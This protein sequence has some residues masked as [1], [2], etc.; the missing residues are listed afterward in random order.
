VTPSR[1]PSFSPAGRGPSTCHHG[2]VPLAALASALLAA[3]LA[4]SSERRAPSLVTY[5]LEERLSAT[6]PA[7]ERVTAIGARV[8]VAGEQARVEISGSFPRARGSLLL[9]DGARALLVDP[10]E[11]EAALL[12]GGD[13]AALFFAPAAEE[14][15]AGWRVREK[16]VAVVPDGAGAPFQDLP[17]RRWRVRVDVFLNVT[18]PNRVATLRSRVR[19]TIETADL[20]EAS[21]RFDDLSRLFRARGEVRE[22]LEK[23]L[24]DVSGFPVRAVLDGDTEMTAEAIGPANGQSTGERPARTTSRAERTVRDLTRRPLTRADA[25]LFAVPEDARMRGP[26]RLVRQDDLAR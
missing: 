20:P 26:E 3:I 11:H 19:G 21:S 15:G 6:T 17:T 18:T 23:R 1:A 12:P 4:P 24:A 25:A 10:R 16:E 7:G 5:A 8:R 9:L 13:L 2:P 22:E 14:S